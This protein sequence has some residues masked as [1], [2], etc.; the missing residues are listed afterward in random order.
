M[1]GVFVVSL[2]VVAAGAIVATVPMVVGMA[3][4]AIV[5]IVAAVVRLC[6]VQVVR[7]SN[8]GWKIVTQSD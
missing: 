3:I 6:A 1:T 2:A 7:L 4:V 8:S 5:G